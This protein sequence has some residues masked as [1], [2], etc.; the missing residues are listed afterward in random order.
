MMCLKILKC[1]LMII[2]L[3]FLVTVWIAPV[4]A[5]TWGEPDST[6]EYPY[7]GAMIDVDEDG[8]EFAS[9]LCS[10]SLIH[11]H[12]FLIEGH[13]PLFFELFGFEPETIRVTFDPGDAFGNTGVWVKVLAM[14]WHPGFSL[15]SSVA[16]QSRD[17][18]I[19]I[20]ES[21]IDIEPVAL[22]PLPGAY[23]DKLKADKVLHKASFI[24]AGYGTSLE[25]PP[26]QIISPDGQRLIA[27]SSKFKGLL[28]QH[29]ITQQN[30]AA[31]ANGTCF[32]D[33][34]GP[35][36]WMD[37][38]LGAEVVVGVTS[39]GDANCVGL[40]VPCRID[41]PEV[42]NFIHGVLG[43]FSAPPRAATRL[44]RTWASVKKQ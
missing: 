22:P 9:G 27:R 25:W 17:I 13:C 6:N 10:S 11:L 37:E 41:T 38:E 39:W 15:Q 30:I 42:L 19:L 28:K 8:N 21:V 33:S 43:V 24:Q 40:D 26:P 34:G 29:I 18:G 31:G 23:L 20:L 16:K 12:V 1:G 4:L 35:V 36:L 44:T 7:V 3:S 2:A 32:G 14:F 5:I